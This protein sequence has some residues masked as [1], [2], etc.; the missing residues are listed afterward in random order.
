VYC[1]QKRSGKVMTWSIVARDEITGQMGIAVATR[2]FAVGARVPFIAPG[3]GAI[4][5]QALVN[6]YFGIDGLAMLRK[7]R[8]PQEILDV[9]KAADP[10]H[11]HRQVHLIHANGQTSAYTGAACLPWCGHLQAVG[12]SLAG[13]LLTGPQV[14]AETLSAYMFH[15]ELPFARRLIVAMLAGDAAGGDTRGKQSASLLIMGDNEWSALDL[16]VDDHLDPLLE[17]SRL[18]EVSHEEWTVF[19]KFIPTRNH[20]GGITDYAVMEAATNQY[21]RV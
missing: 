10:G 5:T 7:G 6:P 2:F 13:N 9:L 14:L 21:K 11:E 19:C 20:P 1:Q 8:N 4:A 3:L 17:L 18:E 15:R 16:R 12:I